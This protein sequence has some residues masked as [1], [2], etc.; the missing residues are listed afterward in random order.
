MARTF[1][2]L[3]PGGRFVV[4][5]IM[6]PLTLRPGR[7]SALRS[8]VW[9]MTKKG[10]PGLWRVTKNAVRW[11]KGTGEYPVDPDAWMTMLTLAGFSDVGHSSIG[12]ETGVVWGVKPAR[13]TL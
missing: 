11:V 6:V 7:S 3:K 5:D 13:P 1:Q 4:S 10:I 2:Q 8:K 12:S 9:R